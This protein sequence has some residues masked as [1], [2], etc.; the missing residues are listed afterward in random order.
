MMVFTHWGFYIRW[1]LRWYEVGQRATQECISPEKKVGVSHRD[2]RRALSV[3][4]R[5]F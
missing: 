5:K 3:A 4:L 2:S 1:G